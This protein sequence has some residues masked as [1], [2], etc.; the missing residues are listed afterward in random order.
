MPWLPH[1][2]GRWRPR[3]AVFGIGVGLYAV[4]LVGAGDVKLLLPVA[5]IMAR[6]AAPAWLLFLGVGIVMALAVL[7]TFAR[8]R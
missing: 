8:P 3:L 4:S 6:L 7:T 2:G 1:V 5:L